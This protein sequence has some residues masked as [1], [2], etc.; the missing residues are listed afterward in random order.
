VKCTEFQSV[1]DRC[2][3]R[4]NSNREI[5][6]DVLDPTALADRPE[7]ERNG[8]VEAF[9]GYFGRVLDPFQIADGD[10]AGTG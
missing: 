5:L 10:A 4:Q 9:S 3:S 6:A 2:I 8:F 7:P 1:L